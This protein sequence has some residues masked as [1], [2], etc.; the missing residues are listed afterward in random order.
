VLRLFQENGHW[1]ALK[2]FDTLFAL[3]L[4]VE[5]VQPPPMLWDPAEANKKQS[6]FNFLA[7]NR[8]WGH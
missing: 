6:L 7:N 8:V 1:Q 5:R 3:L 4:L 2:V